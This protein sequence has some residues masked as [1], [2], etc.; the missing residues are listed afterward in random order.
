[1][2]TATRPSTEQRASIMRVHIRRQLAAGGG[3]PTPVE[4]V[5]DVGGTIPLAYQV[6]SEFPQYVRPTGPR[7]A[8]TVQ[9]VTSVSAV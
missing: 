9:R 4:I 7:R 5:G 6:L 3:V 1:M 8:P 2:P